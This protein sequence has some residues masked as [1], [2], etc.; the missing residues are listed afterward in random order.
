MGQ[1]GGAS[2]VSNSLTAATLLG[3]FRNCG[4]P[5]MDFRILGPLEVI[6]D[7]RAIGLG[8][9]KQQALL[10]VLLLHPNEVVSVSRLI[11]ELWGDAPPAPAT[12]V[13]QGYVSGLRKA[14]GARTIITWAGGYSARVE[15][16]CLDSTRFESL[17]AAGRRSLP[18]DPERAV[19]LF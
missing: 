2:S 7:G 10:A 1:C 14:L 15:P 9:A 17:T 3:T 6:E 4:G 12:K 11:D 5:A 18:S 8:A 19:E 13:I 16:D